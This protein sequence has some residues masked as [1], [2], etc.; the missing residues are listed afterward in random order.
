MKGS[1]GRAWW[2]WAVVLLAFALIGAAC[3]DDGDAET[4]AAPQDTTETTA[5]AP[6]EPVTIGMVLV[7]PRDDRGWSQAHF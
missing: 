2:R 4:T 5:S 7:G 3:S 6:A 1:N